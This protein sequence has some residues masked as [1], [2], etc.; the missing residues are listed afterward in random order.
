MGDLGVKDASIENINI[1]DFMRAVVI[2]K[3]GGP[4]VLQIENVKTPRPANDE[5][6]I[7]VEM[8]GLNHLDVFAR[9]G[10]SGPGVQKKKLPHVSGVD[11]V[12]HVVEYG[13]S[14]GS[15][16]KR[17]KLNERVLINPTFGCNECQYCR[18]GETSMCKEYKIIGEHLWG[19]LAQYVVV[20]AKNIIPVPENI[21]SSAAAAVPAVYTTA[22]RGV[23]TVGKIKPSDTVLVVGASGGLGTAQVDIALAA[24]ATVLGTAS[25]E[26]KR[27]RAL[28]MGVAAMFDSNSNWQKDVLEWTNG[29]VDLVFDSVGAPTIRSSINSL[30]MGGKLVI[31]GATGGDFPEISIREIYQRH[32][33]ILGAPMGNWKDFLQVTDL[34]WKKKL[35]PQVH[36]IYPLEQI[37]QAEQA[38]E[39]REHFGKIIVQIS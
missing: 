13:T 4:E 35:N 6:L 27:K 7:K 10:L 29:G 19:G 32:R 18:A 11:I 28:E 26:E 21:A 24:G 2:R 37:A 9:E 12:G 1:P 22:W 36:A 15:L 8:T 25:S 31:S 38:I 23:V 5:V 14:T 20:P 39:K 30:R 17:P 3:N 34:V 16:D 33:Q